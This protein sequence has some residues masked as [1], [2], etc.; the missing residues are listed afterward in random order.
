MTDEPKRYRGQRGPNKIKKD[1]MPTI[2][3]RLPQD[4]IDYYGRSTVRMR[5][6]LVDHVRRSRAMDELIATSEEL[7]LYDT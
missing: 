6:V 1:R 5:D 3:I 4:V 2:A 7:G